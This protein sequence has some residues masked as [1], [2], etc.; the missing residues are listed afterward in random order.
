MRR[1]RG[2]TT[3]QLGLETGVTLCKDYIF[4]LFC[5]MSE[6]RWVRRKEGRKK[7]GP[8]KAPTS[9]SH[10]S[11]LPSYQMHPFNSTKR[12]KRGLIGPYE[13]ASCLCVAFPW[14]SLADSC[15]GGLKCTEGGFQNAIPFIQN[16]R[17]GKCIQHSV[18][19]LWM[20]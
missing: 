15:M 7:S 16:L 11:L 13:H 9:P 19:H 5:C 3:R 4:T 6:N 10:C 20:R 8:A 17:A 18:I 14:T 2:W 1:R 12:W